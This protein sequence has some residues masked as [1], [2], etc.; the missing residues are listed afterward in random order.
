MLFVCKKCDYTT[1][2]KFNYERHLLRKKA[3]DLSIVTK[4]GVEQYAKQNVHS[5]ACEVDLA[6]VNASEVDIANAS[7]V[8]IAIVDASQV[9]VDVTDASEVDISGSDTYEHHNLTCTACMKKFKKPLYLKRHKKCCKNLHPLQCPTCLKFFADK[10]SKC[11]HIKNAKC[12]AIQKEKEKENQNTIDHSIIINNN[13]SHNHT[14]NNISHVKH[15]H[16]HINIF[17]EEDLTYLMNDAN[18]LQKLKTY[19]KKGVYGLADIIKE[20]HCNKAKP[21]NNTIIKPLD[22]GDG[23]YIMGDDKEWEYREFEDIRD[24]L[25]NT[26]TKYVDKYNKMKNKLGIKLSDR[27][28]KLFIQT[29]MYKLL[30]LSGDIPLDLDEELGIYDE[31]LEQHIE[32]VKD[33]QRKFDKATM[34]KLY[35]YTSTNYKKELGTFKKINSN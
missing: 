25:S 20:V 22:Y 29:L 8:D 3:C 6:I 35:E 33:I 26:F 15:E 5:N 34:S 14:I 28:E 18:L 10:S 12:V 7:E 16:V 31:I 27:R 19:G 21:E 11:R 2:S 24:T 9:D 23:V 30:A 4:N 1:Q 13:G 17:G 32:N